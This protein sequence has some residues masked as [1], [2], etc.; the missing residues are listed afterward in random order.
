MKKLIVAISFLI[1][2]STQAQVRNYTKK[3][4]SPS[5]SSGTMVKKAKSTGS[6][7]KT[8]QIILV[9]GF[10]FST[11][12]GENLDDNSGRPGYAAGLGLSNRLSDSFDIEMNALYGTMGSEFDTGAQVELSYIQIPLLFNF[13]LTQSGF[14][15]GV[16]PQ[17]GFLLSAQIDGEDFIDELKSYDAGIVLN[18][19]IPFSSKVG[20]NVRYYYGLTNNYDVDDSLTLNNRALYAGLYVKF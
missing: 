1:V 6:D 16:G 4:S 7:D 11:L 13:K 14:K 12:D 15:L 3:S 18:G 10:Q 5:T 9:G 19:A 20:M 17:V 2:A 8:P